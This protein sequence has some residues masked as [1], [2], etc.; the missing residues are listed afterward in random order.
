MLATTR[1]RIMH[2]DNNNLDV[3]TVDDK[4]MQCDCTDYLGVEI[5]ETISWNKQ[6]DNICTQIGLYKL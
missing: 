6:T 5:D 2:I 4:L 1:Q 3:H